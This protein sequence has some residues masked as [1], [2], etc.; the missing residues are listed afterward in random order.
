MKME[1][2]F[3]PDP[4]AHKLLDHIGDLLS[5]FQR[6]R[7]DMMQLLADAANLIEKQFSLKQVCI[8]MRGSDGIYRYRVVVGCRPE[9]E[10]AMR[11]LGYTHEQ[12]VDDN[13]YKGHVISK[14]TKIYLAEDKPWSEREKSTYDL[15]AL[16]GMGRKSLDHF[17]EGDYTNIFILGRNDEILG[18]IEFNCTSSRKL[19]DVSSLRWIEF[20]GQVI[21]A[22]VT[23]RSQSGAESS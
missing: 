10:T 14:Y 20:I 4:K 16:I 6:S 1:Y 21:S 13:V 7:L 23:S 5:H 9:I 8:A 22:A 17:L 3:P 12:V 18:W 2:R 11:E 15:P 19:L